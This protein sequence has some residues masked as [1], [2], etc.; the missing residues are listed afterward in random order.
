MESIFHLTPF[1]SLIILVLNAW[2]FII[3]PVIVIRKLNYLT[4]VMEAQME[5]SED[6]SESQA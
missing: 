2:I 1:Q 4:A 5:E 3:F 6:D